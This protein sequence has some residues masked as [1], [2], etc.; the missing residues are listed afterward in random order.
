MFMP[1]VGVQAFVA[2]SY[3]SALEVCAPPPATRTRPSWRRT[4]PCSQRGTFSVPPGSQVPV[5]GS[6]SSV[7]DSPTPPTTR[8]R[9]F[10]SGVAVMLERAT[11]MLAV[12]VQLPVAVLA[13]DRESEPEASAGTASASNAHVAEPTDLMLMTKPPF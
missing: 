12:A 6:Y 1:P 10:P 13:N 9:P 5:G 3:S 2:G 4:A 7:V 8:T 11:D